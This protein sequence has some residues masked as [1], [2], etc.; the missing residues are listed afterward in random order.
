MSQDVE[1]GSEIFI[2]A[3]ES[4]LSK[5]IVNKISSFI[6]NISEIVEAHLPQMYIPKQI[7]PPAQVLILI[8]QENIDKQ[9]V[10]DAVGREIFNLL[11]NDEYIDVI[12]LNA[13]NKLLEPIRNANCTIKQS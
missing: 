1:A 9:K 5:D 6:E 7:D 12:P 4:P 13:D 10:M 11:P 3:P 2:G 8:M